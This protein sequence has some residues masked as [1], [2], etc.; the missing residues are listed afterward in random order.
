MSG[1]NKYFT[2]SVFFTHPHNSL[3]K[4][5]WSEGSVG[6]TVSLLKNGACFLMKFE[7]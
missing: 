4:G 7:N 3:T 2:V 6:G 5:S 1:T